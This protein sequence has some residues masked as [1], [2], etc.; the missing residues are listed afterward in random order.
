[1]YVCAYECVCV[2]VCLYV[3]LCACVCVCVRVVMYVC[4]V[5]SACMLQQQYFV[6]LLYSRPAVI[7]C[8]CVLRDSRS[9]RSQHNRSF[10]P[11]ECRASQDRWNAPTKATCPHSLAAR[12]RRRSRGARRRRSGAGSNQHQGHGPLAGE[13]AHALGRQDGYPPTVIS[14]VRRP[15]AAKIHTG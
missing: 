15:L 7:C 11:A 12:N 14:S 9:K 13:A 2:H 1:M 4:I 10:R 3:C 5:L 6:S 8:V